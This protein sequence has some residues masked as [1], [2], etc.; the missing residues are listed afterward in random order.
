MPRPL[1]GAI[2]VIISMM[3]TSLVSS[4]KYL[5]IVIHPHTQRSLSQALIRKCSVVYYRSYCEGGRGE[6]GAREEGGRE[7]GE[8]EEREREE[9]KVRGEGAK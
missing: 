6:E 2:E 7:E 5:T 4:T 1:C 8:R 3:F 9:D